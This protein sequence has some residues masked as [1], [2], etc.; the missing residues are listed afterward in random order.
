MKVVLY[1]VKGS[2]SLIVG[3]S[4]TLDTHYF[5]LINTHI[6]II[7]QTSNF[8]NQPFDGINIDLS[9]IKTPISKVNKLIAKGK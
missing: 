4:P 3:S 9:T 5:K 1:G 2:N 8:K 6:M 7:Y